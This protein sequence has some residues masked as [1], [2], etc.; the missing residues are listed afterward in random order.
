SGALALSAAAQDVTALKEQ[1]RALLK[2]GN[3]AQAIPIYE[4]AV[5]AAS[6]THGAKD[7]KTDILVNELAMA[8][9]NQGRLAEAAANYQ[10]VLQNTEVRNGPQHTEVATCLGNLAAVYDDWG[11]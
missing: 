11:D 9:F 7:Q 4:R 5:A 2:A 8:Y 1:G 10:R 6:R 3:Y